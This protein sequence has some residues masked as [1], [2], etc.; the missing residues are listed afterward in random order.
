MITRRRFNALAAASALASG[1]AAER[2]KALAWPT[3][4]AALDDASSVSE[5][6]A[7][8][9]TKRIAARPSAERFRLA[10]SPRTLQQINARGILTGGCLASRCFAA[11]K[12]LDIQFP[13]GRP[14]C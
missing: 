7:S 3:H 4:Y 2:A 6:V 12:G 11:R 1:I 13:I 14:H 5:V 8:P 10:C 9:W